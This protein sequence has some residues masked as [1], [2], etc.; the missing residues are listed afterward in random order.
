[1]T[2]TQRATCLAALFGVGVVAGAFDDA[3]VVRTAGAYTTASLTTSIWHPRYL[4]CKDE[5]P[6]RAPPEPSTPRVAAPG[7]ELVPVPRMRAPGRLTVVPHLVDDAA[8]AEPIPDRAPVA[9]RG[10]EPPPAPVAPPPVLRASV[11]GIHCLGLV[12]GR[13][14]MMRVLGAPPGTHFYGHPY[15][16][17]FIADNMIA[18]SAFDAKDAIAPIRV[19]FERPLPSAIR[20]H[21]DMERLAMKGHAAMALSELGDVAS[22]PRIRQVLLSMEVLRVGST[23]RDTFQA[24]HRLDRATSAAYALDL[25]ERIADGKVEKG[26]HSSHELGVVLDALD[27]KDATRALSALK[28]IEATGHDGCL[29]T[30]ARLR[31]GDAPLAKT[32]RPDLEGSI[33]TNLVATCYSQIVAEVAPGRSISE[34]PILLL[35]ARWQA[36]ADLAIALRDQ[37]PAAAKDRATLVAAIRK[38]AAAAP[39][40]LRDHDASYRAGALATLGDEGALRDIYAIVDDPSDDTDRPWVAATY[41]VRARLPDAHAHAQRLLELGIRRAVGHRETDALTSGVA[42]TWGV[43][44]IRA[45]ARQGSPLVALGLL[46][47]DHHAREEGMFAVARGKPQG[48]CDVVAKAAHLTTDGQVTDGA[49]WALTALGA[50]CQPQME[51]LARDRS[52]PGHVRGMAIEALAMMRAPSTQGLADA[53]ANEGA[54]SGV[55]RASLQRTRII[56]SSPE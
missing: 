15:P 16:R 34:L 2:R 10:V 47:T 42:V 11:N 19:V 33:R 48:A 22:A 20:E 36:M 53:W 55:E 37:G 17:Y 14:A 54:R 13:A 56:L 6:L 39:V 46:Q 31:L 24:L 35:R 30:G 45:L 7:E 9:P 44:L 8:L 18:A 1:M 49:F 41:A 23:W 50:Q 25:V 12:R 40:G 4:T 38:K 21:D 52:Q 5:P 3:G 51:G 26:R 28:R 29:V 27:P 32:V 43:Q